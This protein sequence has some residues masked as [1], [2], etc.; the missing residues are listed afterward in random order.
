[1]CLGINL[2]KHRPCMIKLHNYDENLFKDLGE[3]KVN[4]GHRVKELTQL[5]PI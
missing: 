5:S 1:M 3:S 2:R 4:F